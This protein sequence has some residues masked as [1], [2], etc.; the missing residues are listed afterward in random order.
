MAE[1]DLA[2]LRIHVH[3]DASLEGI[4]RLIDIATTN[5]PLTTL[6]NE[7]CHEA[8]H[9]A[10]VD[11]VSVYVVERKDGRDVLALRGNH[12]FPPEAVG[13]VWLELGE[14]ITGF[15][16]ESLNPVTAAVGANDARFHYVPGIGEE[17]FPAFLA[18]PICRSG[19]ALGV[20]VMQCRQRDR[21]STREVT[22]AAALS[23][24][25]VSAIERAQWPSPRPVETSR[26]TRLPG[27]VSVPGSSLGRLRTIPTLSSLR[28]DAPE[29][30]NLD[31]NDALDR[32]LDDIECVL[33][34]HARRGWN[35]PR[36]L[37]RAQSALGDTR[38]RRHAEQCVAEHGL[39]A[40]LS[41]VAKDYAR[42]DDAG[43]LG[44]ARD[45]EE[46]CV[47]IFERAGAARFL[48]TG[49]IV[50][51][52]RI[53]WPLALIAAAENAGALL[54]EDR[55]TLAAREIA[56]AA[57]TPLLERISGLRVWTREGDLAIVESETGQIMVNP[58]ATAVSEFRRTR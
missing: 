15:V 56:R 13:S 41:R 47:V 8:A 58:S 52:Q 22:L 12:G 38:F 4:M 57:G 3:G 45:I 28:V 7:M 21:F 30:T 43:S 54:A 6:L 2:G 18:V 17:F 29:P 1:R 23:A 53:G 24:P 36:V 39:L 10:G 37:S 40:G 20:L 51:A 42:H 46:L 55:A 9:I 49:N 19:G 5:H 35:E 34:K 48:R 50:A 14:G 44:H 27:V 32:L 16:A 31:V 11:V 25:F 26:T 33:V